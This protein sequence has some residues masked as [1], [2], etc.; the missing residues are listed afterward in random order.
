MSTHLYLLLAAGVVAVSVAGSRQTGESE[1]NIRIYSAETGEVETVKTVNKSDAEWKAQLTPEQYSVMRLK[2]TERPFSNTCA[3]PAQGKTGI[4]KCVGCG[5]DLFK[6]GSKFESGTGWPSFWDPVSKLNVRLEADHSIGRE[7]TE[8]LCARCGAHLGHVFDDGP[9]P[10]GKRYC[11]NTVA[12]KLVELG[13][14]VRREKAI[15]AAGCFWGV[16]DAFRKLIGKGVISTRVGYTGGHLKNPT[17]E[18]VC[19]HTTGHAEAV[20]I[21]YDP[22]K[23]SYDRLLKVFWSIHDPTTPNRQGPDVG[24]NYRSAV[25]YHTPQQRALAEESKARLEKSK[26]YKNPVVTEI[27]AAGMFYPA[28]D[29]HQQYFEKRGIEPACHVPTGE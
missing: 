27:T 8:V 15:F 17:Y 6:N 10:T 21:E 1:V 19:S 29:Y 3:L 25:F 5:T 14:Q 12:L 11:I 2:G 18:A 22:N 16:E 26:R 24:S 28:E 23:I 4:Y 9:P 20:E 13:E 7:R